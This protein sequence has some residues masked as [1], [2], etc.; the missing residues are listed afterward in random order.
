M[1]VIDLTQR[2]T[3]NWDAFAAAREREASLI[4]INPRPPNELIE[5]GTVDLSVGTRC[6]DPV[7]GEHF[8]IPEEGFV[9]LARTSVV[10]DSAEK[11]ALPFNVFGLISG[12]GKFIYQA[13]FTS[14]GKIDPGYYDVLKVSIYNAGRNP[15]VLKRREPICAC[16]FLEAGFANRNPPPK[17]AADSG[18]K[19]RRLSRGIQIGRSIRQ[20]STFIVALLGLL[21]A[22][23]TAVAQWWN[24]IDFFRRG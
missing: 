23:A 14:P 9:L 22:I 7:T 15:I 16:Y 13:C 19:E 10:I 11:V 18:A 12:K 2:L 1:A 17:H 6:Y 24:A 3:D 5:S 8:S 4:F 20:N 21:I